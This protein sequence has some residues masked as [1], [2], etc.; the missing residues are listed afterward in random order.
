M[1]TFV[2]APASLDNCNLLQPVVYWK[3][4]REELGLILFTHH[5]IGYTYSVK[6]KLAGTQTLALPP[7]AD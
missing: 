1:L 4:D 2:R 3:T 5:T 7:I 6:L